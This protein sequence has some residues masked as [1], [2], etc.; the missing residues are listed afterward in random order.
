MEGRRR[1]FLASWCEVSAIPAWCRAWLQPLTHALPSEGA[2][3]AQLR[4]HLCFQADEEGMLRSWLLYG[5][6]PSDRLG[7]GSLAQNTQ[8]EGESVVRPLKP[9]GSRDAAAQHPQGTFCN[10][11]LDFFLN[12]PPLGYPLLPCS[13]SQPAANLPEGPGE[14]AWAQDTGRLTKG[15]VE[16]FDS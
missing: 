8:Q 9:G 11:R 5:K 1:I 12:P 13:L 2:G 15:E 3:P 6:P 16:K 4:R 7:R 10:S 14:L